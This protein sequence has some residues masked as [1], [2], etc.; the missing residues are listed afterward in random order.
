[1]S[2]FLFY[3]GMAIYLISFIIISYDLNS[4]I[5]D[6]ES[7]DRIRFLGNRPRSI[8]NLFRYL[9]RLEFL[10]SNSFIVISASILHVCTT[11][12]II[13]NIFSL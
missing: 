8:I 1:M 9:F 2:D 3:Y 7:P 12:F 11:V 13:Y 4:K 5:P 10:K 6:K